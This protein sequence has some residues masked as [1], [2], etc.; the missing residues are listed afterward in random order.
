MGEKAVDAGR[1]VAAATRTAVARLAARALPDA[2]AVGSEQPT[3]RR[4]L[5]DLPGWTCWLL[6]AHE[7]VTAMVV[8]SF[9][10]SQ[11]PNPSAAVPCGDAGVQAG[12]GR[13]LATRECWRGCGR[14]VVT[15]GSHRNEVKT[16]AAA[17]PLQ[18]NLSLVRAATRA[19]GSA[20]GDLVGTV[21]E[22]SSSKLAFLPQP[23]ELNFKSCLRRKAKVQFPLRGPLEF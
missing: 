2:V 3:W 16:L 7:S 1:A 9:L 10:R 18:S 17:P 19:C 12:W 20:V 23:F 21:R 15:K 13:R 14:R 6:V 8:V 22:E 4:G 11:W 5:P